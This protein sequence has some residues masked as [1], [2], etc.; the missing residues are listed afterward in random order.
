M[1]LRKTPPLI[2]TANAK[3]ELESLYLRRLLL[4]NLIRSMEVYR[5]LANGPRGRSRKAA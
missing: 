1:S 3:E 4:D 5:Q 2:S